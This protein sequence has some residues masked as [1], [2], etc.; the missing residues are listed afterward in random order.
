MSH[1]GSAEPLP[2][3]GR[4]RRRVTRP[5]TTTFGT[6]DA[7]PAGTCC[8]RSD[9]HLVAAAGNPVA[10][11]IA[12]ADW[13]ADR[14][15]R[16]IQPWSVGYGRGRRGH[17]HRRAVHA[18][19]GCCPARLTARCA[20]TLRT[21]ATTVAPRS[22]ACHGCWRTTCKP[23]F[24]STPLAPLLGDIP[25]DRRDQVQP[26]SRHQLARHQPV[27]QRTIWPSTLTTSSTNRPKDPADASGRHGG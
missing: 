10:E 6:N 16:V 3:S 18:V 17:L 21:G 9:G 25:L 11:T 4:G 27:P 15:D 7:D 26:R 24:G 8:R 22:T 14:D 20:G 19:A 23:T 2:G 5:T 1:V 13:D 12:Y